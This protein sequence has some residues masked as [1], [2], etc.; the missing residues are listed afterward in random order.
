MNRRRF[1]EPTTYGK[2]PSEYQEVEYLESTGTQYINIINDFAGQNVKEEFDTEIEIVYLNNENWFFGYNQ[3]SNLQG[4]TIGTPANTKTICALNYAGN[5]II[6]SGIYKLNE[7]IKINVQ[8]NNS[9]LSKLIVDEFSGDFYTYNVDKITHNAF[10]LFAGT[11]SIGGAGYHSHIKMKI[12]KRIVEGK[13]NRICIPCYRKA[14]G[15]P[16]MYDTVNNVFYTNQGTGEFIIGPEVKPDCDLPGEL[17]PDNPLKAKFIGYKKVE[18]IYRLPSEYQE[19]EYLENS[20]T[21]YLTFPIELTSSNYDET[22]IAEIM[23]LSNSTRFSYTTVFGSMSYPNYSSYVSIGDY[24]RT[25]QTGWSVQNL[26]RNTGQWMKIEQHAFD[27]FVLIDGVRYNTTNRTS[28]SNNGQKFTL[29]AI[30]DD[31]ESWK[32][33]VH[34][35]MRSKELQRII[36]GVKVL[37]IIPCYRK[38]D[39]KPGMY[40]IVNNIF[41]TNQGTG[42]F[43]VGPDLVGVNRLWDYK[44]GLYNPT[45]GEFTKLE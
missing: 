6:S 16:G 19:V 5:T 12:F 1:K 17:G 24:V 38:S 20:G 39:N 4:R 35:G 42:E 40:D 36:N 22:I 32:F 31:S 44:R 13:P 43:L 18:D 11:S 23:S 15:K 9:G 14:D 28:F 30:N 45:T 3:Y 2:L 8:Y 33:R 37:H 21:Q 29:F 10:N 34:L 27:R 7:F 25:Y 26:T 41:Y